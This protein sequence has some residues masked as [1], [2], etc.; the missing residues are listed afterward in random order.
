M[1]FFQTIN[2][3]IF[4]LN[5]DILTWR[6][7]RSFLELRTKVSGNQCKYDVP[8]SSPNPPL[9][10]SW[11]RFRTVV[12]LSSQASPVVFKLT[13]LLRVWFRPAGLGTFP[14]GDPAAG[15][16]LKTVITTFISTVSGRQAV[17]PVLY[18]SVRSV[19]GSVSQ[20]FW[21]QDLWLEEGCLATRWLLPPNR[22]PSPAA[23]LYDGQEGEVMWPNT[24]QDFELVGCESPAVVS[25]Q[26]MFIGDSTNR[27][28]MYF[29][30]ERVNSSLEDWGKAHNTLVY[31]N[32]NKGLTQ[33]SYSYYPQFWLPRDQRPTFREALLQLL[34]RW[35]EVT[36]QVEAGPSLLHF[37]Y[38]KLGSFVRPLRPPAPCLCHYLHKG[39]GL[40][41]TLIW[42]F[43]WWEE[44][45]GSTLITWGWSRKFW[46][47]KDTQ[48]TPVEWQTHR[49]ST[50]PE[51]KHQETKHWYQWNTISG[52]HIAAVLNPTPP[53]LRRRWAVLILGFFFSR[54]SLSN[55]LV[56]VKSLGM[57]FHLPVDG[58]RSLSLVGS[59]FLL[60]VIH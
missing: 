23:G 56:V 47:G 50:H 33:V 21:Q 37:C 8:L 53:T 4:Y 55:I 35:V 1:S 22:W 58:I 14:V 51:T 49:F 25:P 41:R 6:S 20:L 57:G 7:W 34:A 52:F 5:L 29:L 60:Q 15:W 32:L 27:G 42:Q 39:P 46:T 48:T 36:C 10:P 44:S 12:F 28:M 2:V 3:F 54:E 45:S 40:W 31:Q 30:M 11:P 13:S 26:V 17:T 16:L 24:I 9:R 18:P 19:G 59:R 43:W 38:M